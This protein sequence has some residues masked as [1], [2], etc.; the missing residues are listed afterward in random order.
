M[1]QHILIVKIQLIKLLQTTLGAYKTAGNPKNDE[2]QRGVASMFYSFFDK[3]AGLRASGNKDLTEETHKPVIKK[4]KR[5]RAYASL[6]L[7]NR[8]T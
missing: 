2:Y 6:Y 4:F 1:M 8:F 7:A 5:T 3:K